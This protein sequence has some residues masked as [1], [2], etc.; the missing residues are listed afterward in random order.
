MADEDKIE[1][2]NVDITPLKESKVPIIFVIGGPGCGKGTQCQKI[3]ELYGFTHLSTG[4]LLRDEVKSGSKR[5]MK[6]ANIMKKGELVSL[7]VVLDL[8]KES[9]IK[10]L[11]TSKGYLI[12]GYPREVNQGIQFESQIKPCSM[13][14]FFDVSDKTMTERCMKRGE[15]SGRADDNEETIKKRLE[16]FHKIS[17]PVVQHYENKVKIINAEVEPTT[18]FKESVVPHFEALKASK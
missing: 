4:D 2:S 15:T 13:V 9:M 16:T 12:D 17:R 10:H 3:V 6:I 8:L 5:G 7:D 14:L 18:L 11:P 1:R